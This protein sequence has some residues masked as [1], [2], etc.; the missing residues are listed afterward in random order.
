MIFDVTIV[1]TWQLG[2][3]VGRVLPLNQPVTLLSTNFGDCSGMLSFNCPGGEKTQENTS[4]CRKILKRETHDCL[5][6]SWAV[7]VWLNV[8]PTTSEFSHEIS[9]LLQMNP[10]WVDITWQCES[11][12]VGFGSNLGVHER[13]KPIATPCWYRS[14]FRCGHPVGVANI[15]QSAPLVCEP[16]AQPKIRVPWLLRKWIYSGTKSWLG[17]SKVQT[18]AWLKRTLHTYR[19]FPYFTEIHQQTLPRHRFVATW[20]VRI[21]SYQSGI[22]TPEAFIQ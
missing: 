17:E 3:T 16:L 14:W 4:P 2:Y 20:W 7:W 21:S 12:R 11:L 1:T 22:N 6:H 9:F 18:S 5:L 13:G 8:F 15:V 10:A 19:N